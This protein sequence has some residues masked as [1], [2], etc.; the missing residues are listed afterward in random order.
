MSIDS[1]VSVHLSLRLVLSSV[2]SFV[3]ALTLSVLVLASLWACMS[4]L[5]SLSQ[6]GTFLSDS[7]RDVFLDGVGQHHAVGHVGIIDV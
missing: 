2:M 7:P 3:A 1:T 4:F 6:Q 5:H